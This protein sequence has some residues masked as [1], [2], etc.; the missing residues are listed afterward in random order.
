MDFSGLPDGVPHILDRDAKWNENSIAYKGTAARLADVPDELQARLQKVAADAFRA[1]RVRDYG[2]IDLRL[3]P[4]GDIYVI[5]V[6][7]NCYLEQSSEFSIAAAAAGMDYPTLI[8]R[9][10][11]LAMERHGHG[12]PTARKRRKKRRSVPQQV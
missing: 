6:N 7:A 9:I 10:V 4:T 1:L 8:N 3:T 5:E 12:E 2:R 11:E